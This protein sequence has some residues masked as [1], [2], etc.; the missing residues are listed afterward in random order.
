MVFTLVYQGDLLEAIFPFRV[1][2]KRPLG[3]PLRLLQV[4]MHPHMNLQDVVL[5]PRAVSSGLLDELLEF[6][7]RQNDYKCDAIH[8]GG[9]LQDSAT[10]Q[11]LECDD[12]LR[13]TV[14]PTVSCD[15]LPVL[16]EENLPKAVSRN[17]RG[18]LRKARHK[19]A[20]RGNVEFLSTRDPGVLQEYLLQFLDIE[21]SG[22]KGANGSQSAIKIHAPLSAFYGRLAE[23]FGAEEHCEINLLKVDGQVIAGQ[24]ALIVGD[25][26]YLLKIGYDEEYA[27]L[28]PGNTLLAHTLDR[29]SVEED[30]RH[31]NLITD[32]AW[33]KSW[34]PSQSQVFQC[35]CFSSSLMA[36]LLYAY[37]HIRWSM[38]R[39]RS[40][41]KFRLSGLRI[42]QP[43]VRQPGT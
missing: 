29:L 9:V 41:A 34:R 33:H 6:L 11:L 26:T 3:L 1:V 37:T 5:S 40:T 24:F 30:I 23:M 4:P 35:C 12:S 25:T 39:L 36:R 43:A 42:R 13:T 32:A 18:N 21:A 17:L 38:G 7:N 28:A 8:F 20:K 27:E 2:K 10:L 31:V 14:F 22:W 16:S 15:Y 19:L